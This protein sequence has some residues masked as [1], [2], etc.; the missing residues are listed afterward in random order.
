MINHQGG[1]NPPQAQ[2][3]RDGAQTSVQLLTKLN[4]DDIKTAIRK[5]VGAPDNAT[6]N[7]IISE[8]MIS[9]YDG[10]VLTEKDDDEDYRH[11]YKAHY[12]KCAEV[13]T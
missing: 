9:A 12:I 10:R 7:I 3:H 1:G 2:G 11:A 6:V 8:H 4:L 13:I 5:H